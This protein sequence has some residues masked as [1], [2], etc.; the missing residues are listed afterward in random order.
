MAG[1]I[2]TLKPEILE[3]D[4]TAGL[5]H[6]A[7]RLYVSGYLL[8][9]DQGNL[10][11]HPRRLAAE[12][13]WLRE[14]SDV[15][16]TVSELSRTGLWSLYEVRGQLY[17]A[18]HAWERHQRIDHPGKPRVPEP[19]DPG[20]TPVIPASFPNFPEWLRSFS[21]PSRETLAPDPDLRSTTTTNDQE[22]AQPPEERR[23]DL[24][25]QARE[26]YA[27]W[28]D[29]MGKDPKRCKLTSERANRVRA[30]LREGYSLEDVKL[31]ID[32]CRATPHN[33]G[34]NEQRQPYNDLELICRNGSNLERFR[35]TGE[36]IRGNGGGA[37]RQP[38]LGLDPD[39]LERQLVP[40]DDVSDDD[41]ATGAWRPR[42]REDLRER[43]A[44]RMAG[45]AQ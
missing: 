39:D 27:Y 42:A 16:A 28:L 41:L 38:T 18:I 14:V 31:A 35:S 10:R 29:S 45:G 13:F 23:P 12:V 44:K 32:G 1:R 26:V 8:A 22:V 2:R 17:A 15:F 9:D 5:T 7:W 37:P 3:D 33:M 11:A 20:A 4:R 43:I 24:M 40:P 36:G 25:A 30:R 6:A 34:Q 19:S 21:D